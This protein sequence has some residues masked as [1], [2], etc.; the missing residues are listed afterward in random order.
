M[1]FTN[2]V[3][4]VLACAAAVSGVGPLEREVEAAITAA[5]AQTFEGTITFRQEGVFPPRPE[6]A[7]AAGDFGPDKP[8]GLTDPETRAR[9]RQ[10]YRQIHD[11]LRRQS[12]S[13]HFVEAVLSL[14]VGQDGDLRLD[15]SQRG[16][17]P[18][19]FGFHGGELWEYTV[20][21]EI[22]MT[23]QEAALEDPPTVPGLALKQQLN[24][25][26]HLTRLFVNQKVTP[27]L[28]SALQRV[29]TA[30]DGTVVAH[31]LLA[32]GPMQL[33]LADIGGAMRVIEITR[34]HGDQLF[35]TKFSDF[36]RTGQAWLPW[37]VE[38]IEERLAQTPAEGISK[39]VTRTV[40]HVTGLEPT[41]LDRLV[42]RPSPVG[43]EFPELRY[44]HDVTLPDQP[45]VSLG[46]D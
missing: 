15:R 16:S 28:G 26:R 19:S 18:I 23:M 46:D 8:I 37:V 1:L 7:A 9:I 3:L 2:V 29:E 17:S 25:A 38:N 5:A 4:A 40:R 27:E 36:R 14:T 6:L 10:T 35:R 39:R 33:R 45:I 30:D 43:S 34:E 21:G 12:D 11:E 13:V 24:E 41:E 32:E 20:G 31:L 22:L 44:A 42:R